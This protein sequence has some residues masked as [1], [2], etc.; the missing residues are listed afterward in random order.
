MSYEQV[1]E[2][3]SLVREEI[4]AALLE[5]L[6]A[7]LTE[8]EQAQLRECARLI[9]EQQTRAAEIGVEAARRVATTDE[10]EANRREA[11]G[12]CLIVFLVQYAQAAASENLIEM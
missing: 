6:P 7:L 9:V 5:D 10:E 11:I 4:V 8:G 2:H 3:R 1:Q 12:R